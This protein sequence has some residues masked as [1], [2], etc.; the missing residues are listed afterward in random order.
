[1]KLDYLHGSLFIQESSMT[2]SSWK[3]ILPYSYYVSW[4]GYLNG[5]TANLITFAD[6]GYNI[7]HPVPGGSQTEPFDEPEFDEFL[8]ALDEMGLYLMYDMRWTYQNLTA[9]SAQVERLMSRKSLL[10]WYTADEPDGWGDPLNATSLAYSTIKDLDPYHPVSLVLNCYNFYFKEYTSG[11]DIVLTD[12][13]PVATNVTWSVQWDT[14]CNTTYGDCG[15]DNCIDLFHDIPRRMDA[16]KDYREWLGNV[17]YR[18]PQ[19]LWGVPQA[20]GGSEYWSRAPTAAEK[21]VLDMLFVNHG[22]KGLVAWMFPT[23][24]ELQEVTSQLAKVL[25]TDEVTGY[26]L[27]ADAVQLDV[28]GDNV[29]ELDA[30]GWNVGGKILVSVVYMSYGDYGSPVSVSLPGSVGSIETLWPTVI[31]DEVRWQADGKNILKSSLIGLEVTL[32]LVDMQ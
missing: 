21:V 8:D 4:G 1:V 32:L 24:I 3:P 22:A 15:C 17:G 20:F 11:T 13:Y 27:G 12:P 26:L 16:F 30:A 23:T 14:P 19:P 28:N 29:T 31:N 25:T 9:L 6:L 5:S 2:N 10:L 18:G 7:I